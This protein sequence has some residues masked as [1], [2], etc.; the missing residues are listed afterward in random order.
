MK[1]LFILSVL[2]LFCS[3]CT[4]YQEVNKMAIVD[5]IG[6]SYQDFTYHLY[7]SVS[8]KSKNDD[9]TKSSHKVYHVTGK[10]LGDAFSNANYLDQKQTFYKQIAT[11]IV[12]ENIITTKDK[13]LLSFLKNKFSQ[14]N[15]LLISSSSAYSIMNMFPSHQKVEQFIKEEQLQKATIAPMT[16]DEVYAKYLDKEQE[17]YLFSIHIK[18][19]Q[20][21]TD[22]IKLF[23]KQEKLSNTQARIFQL[24]NHQVKKFNTSVSYQDKTYA[25]TL[26]N[27]KVSNNY[28][29]N[30]IKIKVTGIVSSDD[31]LKEND[32]IDKLQTEL[33]EEITAFIT[34]QQE[35]KQLLSPFINMIYLKERNRKKALDIFSKIPIHV[36]INFRKEAS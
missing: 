1:K 3:A 20:L 10:S 19:Q 6:I 7:L 8:S 24:L 9:S 5:M 12:D 27:L 2:L 18:N 17:A 35:E 23:G 4:P 36:Q 11:V 22:G 28:Q 16:F 15:Y 25:L 21:V 33:K 32:I 29:N 34:K 14:V 30:K 26:K 13:M 31:T